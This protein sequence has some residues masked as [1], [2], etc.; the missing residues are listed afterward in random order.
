MN[1][2]TELFRSFQMGIRSKRAETPRQYVEALQLDYNRLEIG[3]NSGQFHHRKDEAF[4]KPFIE[5]GILKKSNAAVRS[6]E[7]TAYT[8]FGAYSIVF[9][10]KDRSG[11][12]VNFHATRIKLESQPTKYLNDK[13]IYPHYPDPLTRTLYITANILDAATMLQA[14]LLNKREEVM[15][16]Y[17][18]DMKPQHYQAIERLQQLEQ[19]IVIKS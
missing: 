10:L 1:T 14:N 7:M 18:G 9:P 5:L 6:E 12:I 15:A 17:D 13:G 4:R 11:N 8:C 16:L 2:L 3:F 19:I